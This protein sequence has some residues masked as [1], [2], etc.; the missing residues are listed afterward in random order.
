MKL[1]PYFILLGFTAQIVVVTCAWEVRTY[2]YQVRDDANQCAQSTVHYDE[3]KILTN[4]FRFKVGKCVDRG[5]AT[6]HRSLN[7]CVQNVFGRQWCGTF[8]IHFPKP[9]KSVT[10]HRVRLDTESCSEFSMPLDD[11]RTLV[12]I[13]RSTGWKPGKCITKGYNLLLKKNEWC[14]QASS[15]RLCTTVTTFQKAKVGTKAIT[16][17]RVLRDDHEMCA[18]KA[19][20]SETAKE[21]QKQYD[22]VKG[23]C[24]EVGFPVRYEYENICLHND[25]GNQFCGDFDLHSPRGDSQTIYKI[26]YPDKGR[27]SQVV[28][29]R[30]DAYDK[31]ETFG[32]SSGNCTSHGYSNY[33]GTE[34]SCL[35][36]FPCS[37]WCDN[38]LTYTEK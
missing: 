26:D 36:E 7:K 12:N 32:F 8:S 23:N 4:K 17:V 10:A 22:V 30:R 6:A 11:A 13:T 33:V 25:K 35:W 38:F 18:Q 16:T 37:F 28:L 21:L 31:E 19:V 3:A 20:S 1:T 27:C 29:N 15:K 14:G 2:V 24:S 9:S 34:H 5:F